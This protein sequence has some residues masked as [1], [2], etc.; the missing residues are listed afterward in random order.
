[1]TMQMLAISPMPRMP[2]RPRLVIEAVL[3]ETRI[4][5][6]DFYGCYRDKHLVAARALAAQRLFDLGLSPHRVATCLRRDRST[7]LN[8]LPQHRDVRRQRHAATAIM[9][10]LSAEARQVILDYAAA[11]NVRPALLIAQWLNE[12]AEYEGQARMR[13]AA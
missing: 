13:A 12:R 10:H 7:V 4:C 1:M 2:E 6:K 11:E 3:S 8:Y 5:A 9:H